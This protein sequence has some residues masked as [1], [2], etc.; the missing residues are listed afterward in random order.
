[1]IDK[2]TKRTDFT[3]SARNDL[4]EIWSYVNIENSRA[5]DNLIKE[6]IQKFTI[7]A[8]NPKRW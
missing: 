8:E 2:H 6:F 7:L 1:M 5:A 3:Q 4:D